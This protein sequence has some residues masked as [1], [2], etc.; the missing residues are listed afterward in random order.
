MQAK[1]LNCRL[2]LVSIATVSLHCSVMNCYWF[3]T[4]RLTSLDI[5]QSVTT[6]PTDVFDTAVDSTCTADLSWIHGT[7]AS[8]LKIFN[9]KSFAKLRL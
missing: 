3:W 2:D 9:Q 7:T 6:L 8:I 5:G 1:L 4:I